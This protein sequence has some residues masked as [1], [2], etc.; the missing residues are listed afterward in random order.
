MLLRSNHPDNITFLSDSYKFYS[1]YDKYQFILAINKLTPTKIHKI[2]FSLDG[3]IISQITDLIDEGVI[4]RKSGN[5]IIIID[6]F[7][8]IGI[9][10]DI[11]L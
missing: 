10:Q 1:L 7:N 8:V 5:K 6:N 4:F 11:T 9:K 2:K 3:V